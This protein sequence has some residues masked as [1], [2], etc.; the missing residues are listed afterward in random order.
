[1][2]KLFIITV[3]MALTASAFAYDFSAVC[4]SGQTLYYSY[5]SD[6]GVKVV[7]PSTNWNGYTQPTGHLIIPETVENEGVVYTV[8]SIGYQAFYQRHGLTSVEI[9]NTI[10]SIQTAAFENSGLTSVE[11]P[12]SVTIIQ[13]WAFAM[14]TDLLSLTIGSSVSTMETGAFRSCTGLQTIHCN[15]HTPPA[16]AHAG[17]NS[18]N[19]NEIF[20]S[21]PTDIPVY[22]SCLSYDQFAT[23]EQ[24]DQFSN[25]QGVFIG[26]P[27][28]NVSVNVSGLGTVETIS[29]PESCDNPT[30]TVLAIPNPGHEFSYWK[31]GIEMVSFSPEYTFVLDQNITL[32][33]CFDS[34]PIVYDS[35]AFPDHVIGRQI[36]A[37]GQVTNEYPSDFI[38]E[39]NGEMIQFKL[40]SFGVT[41]TYTFADYPTM[42]SRIS[43]C[44][45]SGHPIYFDEYQYTYEN[46]RIKH[47][48][49]TTGVESIKASFDYFYDESWHLTKIEQTTTYVYPYFW[50]HHIFEYEN[51][52]RTRIDVNYESYDNVNFICANKTTKH[53]NQRQQLLSTQTDTYN[54]AGDTT[55]MTLQ[56]YTYTPNNKTDHVITQSFA[57]G[58]WVNSSIAQYVYDNKNRV[59]EYQTGS[60]SS[61]N[62]DWNITKKTIYDF[63][64]IEQKLTVSFRKKNND[65]W[66]WDSYS[67]QNM[68]YESD[69]K[70]WNQALA[71]YNSINQFEIDLHYVRKE[72][73]E[74]F[75]IQ[76][77]WYYEIQWDDGSTT[78]QHLEYTS[79]TTI[80][81]SRPKVIVRSN[82]H[83]DRDTITEVTHEYILEEGN[84]V[85]WWNKD[86]QEF[87]ILYDYNAGLGDEWELKVGM[88]SITVH[89]DDVDVFEYGGDTYKRLYISDVDN[90]FNGE[91]VVGFGHMTSFFPEKLM[92]QGKGF[93]L[94]G[95]RCYWVED[96]LLYH[97]GE[98][99]CDAI[100]SELQ[101][102]DEPK[103]NTT[104]A[105]YPNPAT[106][107]LFVETVC[108]PSLPSETKYRIA[109]L[110]GQTLLQG[111]IT[112]ETLQINIEKLPAG[113]YFISVGNTTQKFVVQ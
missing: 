40:P 107:V 48:E 103:D 72:K 69:M 16:F 31:N 76:S 98:E 34:A 50:R 75:P 14:C 44:H 101:G 67:G 26:A 19:N 57:N 74:V 13:A 59:I 15:A 94:N 110:I 43:T 95:L 90:I 21:V 64:D 24:W 30:A 22:V 41:T 9:P 113:M 29:I 32:V 112:N 27:N 2:K 12:N 99:D 6:S 97:N 49:T 85:Y 33:A 78:Y 68:F 82:T 91:I 100:H 3:L 63:D 93:R 87:T 96:A 106:S 7:S 23:N 4:E 71:N 88:E 18:Y 56:T 8:V 89:V 55:S 46:N 77:E 79:D 111:H 35:T 53:Y 65:E 17:N 45:D 73:E 1:M 81:T 92:N 83:Y 86:L 28:L 10:T 37:S 51:N 20:E 36:N 80:G 42:P 102:I 61:E 108:T 105:V 11:I 39:E 5:V 58:E 52:Y 109:N 66:I 54:S 25:L 62:Q 104:F 70:L 38:Y 84:K 60:W 47:V